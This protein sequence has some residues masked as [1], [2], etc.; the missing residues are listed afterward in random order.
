MAKLPSTTKLVLYNLSIHMNEIGEECY[1]GVEKQAKDSGL[2]VRTI[3]THLDIAEKHG[4]IK[5]KIHG[6]SGQGWAR[7]EYIATYPKGYEIGSE[8]LIQGTEP[9]AEGTEPNDKKV[10]KEVHSNSPVI[11]LQLNSPVNNTSKTK[12]RLEYP[13]EFDEFWKEYSPNNSSKSEAFK[14]Y[15]KATKKA[16]HATIIRS[17]KSYAEFCSRTGTFIAHATTWLNQGRWEIDYDSKIIAQGKSSYARK[18][19][20]DDV[21]GILV[22]L[23]SSETRT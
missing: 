17:V 9:N 3:C 5:S 23:A 12:R 2:S 7:N 4:F 1:P 6:F 11:T 21:M 15:K 16:D 22:G 13:V 14:S 10:V 18:V 19:N 8:P 20:H